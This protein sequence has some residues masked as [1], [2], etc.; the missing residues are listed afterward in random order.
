MSA[1]RAGGSSAAGADKPGSPPHDR[2]KHPPTHNDAMNNQTTHPRESRCRCKS[3]LIGAGAPTLRPPD[4]TTPDSSPPSAGNRRSHGARQITQRHAMSNARAPI[5]APPTRTATAHPSRPEPINGAGHRCG[6]WLAALIPTLA[7]TITLAAPA[8]LALANSYDVYACYAG[9]GTYLN[10]GFSAASWAAANNNGTNYYY[11]YDQCG[12]GGPNGFGIISRSGYIAPAGDYGQWSFTAPTGLHVR[13]VQLW[14]ALFDYGLGSGG[15]S[16]R[17]YAWNLA[18]GQLPAVGD[19]F[20]GSAEV[21]FG[22]A[23]TGDWTDK[24]I[25]PSNYISVNLASALPATYSYVIGCGFATGCATGGHDPASPSGPDTIVRIYGAIVSVED[26]IPPTL[27]LGTTGLL[28][29]NPQS[30]LV[31]LTINAAAIAGIEKLEVYAASRST[32]AFTEDFTQT[33]NCQFWQAAPCQ[34][35]TGYQY[36]LDTTRLPNG[37][38]YITV[39]AYDPAG[40]V[41][42][43]S[44]PAPITVE[45]SGGSWRLSLH[46]SP[47]RVHRHTTVRLRGTVSTSPR[48]LAGKLIYLQARTVTRARRGHRHANGYGA[49]V[50]FRALRARRDGG[51]ATSYRFKL[52][53]RHRY[54]FQA[55]APTEGGFANATG[56]SAVVDVSET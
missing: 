20:D 24:G 3:S 42:S 50:T 14:R 55:V 21:P 12:S 27:T 30:G 22:T 44:S 54:Q 35:L 33:P 47:R 29:G 31:P 45:N 5:P 16:Q 40:N 2:R 8:P 26:D 28:D 46:V 49:W 15:T 9:Q 10:P 38:Y 41:V 34:N 51:F 19:E 53:G 48:P 32:P 25:V 23:G 1:K 6:R 11:P 7:A 37:S 13:E 52:G 56:Y 4:A 18:D 36:P 43:V 39:K 17:N